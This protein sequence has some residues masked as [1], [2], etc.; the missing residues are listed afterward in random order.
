[1][2]KRVLLHSIFL[3]NCYF[4]FLYGNGN[5]LGYIR[6]SIIEDGVKTVSYEIDPEQARTVRKIFDLY[7]DGK[8]VRAIKYEL[9]SL[10]FKTASVSS[11]K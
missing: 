6:H 10:G 5:V 8:G 11:A 9:E 3:P 7:L 1:M 2:G 4:I